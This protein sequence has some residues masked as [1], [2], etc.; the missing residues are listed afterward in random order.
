MLNT[1]LIFISVANKYL[2][3]KHRKSCG[4]AVINGD[5]LGIGVLGGGD[6]WKKIVMDQVLGQ[7]LN[8]V[9]GTW[10]STWYLVKY[11][12]KYLVKYLK[13][14]LKAARNID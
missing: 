6:S 14:Q 11:F 7:V 10:S 3:F 2:R 12:V 5:R 13:K 4:I 8:Q 1:N 9:L